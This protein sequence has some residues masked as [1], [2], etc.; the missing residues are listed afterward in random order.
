[1]Q[2]TRS[3]STFYILAVTALSAIYIL[4]AVRITFDYTRLAIILFLF[5]AVFIFQRESIKPLKTIVITL[6]PYMAI[7]FIVAK[8]DDFKLG[9]LHPLLITWC[10][11][12][13]AI[14]CKNIIDRGNRKEIIAI[15]LI[16]LTMLLYIMNNTIVA[17]ANSSNII[18]ELTAV[19]TMDDDLRIKYALSNIGGYGIAYGSGAIVV[20]LLTLI[21]NSIKKKWLKIVAFILLGY[22]LYFV[23]NA[24][25]TTLIFL[26]FFSSMVSLYLSEYGQHNRFKL[27]FLGIILLLFTPM[28]MQLL[29]GFYEGTTIG[30]KLVRFNESIFGGGDLTDASGQ[31]SKFQIEAFNMF[32]KS[33]IWGTDVTRNITNATIYGA[34]HS[35]LLSIACSTGLIG[36]YSYY[37]TYW[38]ILKP[39][40]KH[41]ANT[42]KQ[43]VALVLYFFCFSVFNPSEVSEACWIIFL[44]V[45]LLFNLLMSYNAKGIA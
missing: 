36:L 12:F 20:L 9:F 1:M 10:M 25:F 38:A 44:I 26:T 14:L 13:P 33:P 22:F 21:V 3:N 31:R 34:S 27:V 17:M 43:Y 2:H 30:D 42:G 4:P 19:S 5:Y 7:S 24:Q 18:R 45:P 40:F 11:L 29:A 6:L 41:Y 23:L 8:P 37:K 28:L 15:A 35:T 39:I 16:T 32:L